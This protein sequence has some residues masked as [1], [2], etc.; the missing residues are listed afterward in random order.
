MPLSDAWIDF[1]AGWCSGAVAVLA[2]QPVDT[3]LTRYQA[4][5]ASVVTNSSTVMHDSIAIGKSLVSRRALWSGASPMIGAVPL[6]NALLMGGYGI[7]LQYAAAAAAGSPHTNTNTTDAAHKYRAIFVGG[8]TGGVV[9]SFVMS[10]VELVKVAQQVHARTLRQAW[11]SLQRH[12]W[13]AGLGATVLRDGIPHGVWFVAYEASKDVLQRQ[14]VQ[15][16]EMG[17]VTITADSFYSKFGIPLLAGAIAATT[18][19]GVGYPADVIKTRIQAAS[20]NGK[21]PLGIVATAHELIQEA[22]GQVWKGLYR[23]FGLKLVRSIPASM[24]GFTTYEFVKQHI[25][26]LQL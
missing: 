21:T 5:T 23:G 8:C 17:D 10:P 6:Q 13:T 19:W 24:I 18:A 22:E 3:L 20:S 7:G 16:S 15:T 14:Q 9:Q 11:H 1:V 25:S 12:W 4:T 26:T 2:M